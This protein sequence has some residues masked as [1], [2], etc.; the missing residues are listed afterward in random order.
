MHFDIRISFVNCLRNKCAFA[1]RSSVIQLVDAMRT[2]VDDVWN[3]FR[4]LRY[5]LLLNSKI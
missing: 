3:R 2:L 5:S 1:V 4:Y